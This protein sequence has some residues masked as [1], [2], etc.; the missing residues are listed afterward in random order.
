MY[1]D[2]LDNL[3]NYQYQKMYGKNG[4]KGVQKEV[5]VGE[6]SKSQTLDVQRG[7]K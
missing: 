4:Q 7:K 3:P 5:N 1:H 2:F 6:D